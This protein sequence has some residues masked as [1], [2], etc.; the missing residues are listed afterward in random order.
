MDIAVIIGLGV[1]CVIAIGGFV[2]LKTHP[3][4]SGNIE[5]AKQS[6]DK[7][8]E[9]HKLASMA[10]HPSITAHARE[11]VISKITDQSLLMN[12]QISDEIRKKKAQQSSIKPVVEKQIDPILLRAYAKSYAKEIMSMSAGII[13]DL[14]DDSIASGPFVAEQYP[15]LTRIGRRAYDLGGYLLMRE[16]IKQI[17]LVYTGYHEAGK[18][19]VI[20]D[21][22]EGWKNKR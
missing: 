16:V 14:N 20:W 19:S 15:D 8:T 3:W 13:V 12:L 21:E 2:Y 9:Q 22:I 6:I 1:T 17:E 5:K 7:V 18:V 10:A 11:Y 4:L